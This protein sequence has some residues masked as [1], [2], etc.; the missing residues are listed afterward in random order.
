MSISGG[1]V[2][3]KKEQSD[4][5]VGK[6]SKETKEVAIWGVIPIGEDM[7]DRQDEWLSKEAIKYAEKER[8]EYFEGAQIV[9]WMH[10]QPGYGTMITV[11]ELKIH[12]EFFLQETGVILLLDPINHIETFCTCEGE[13]LREQTGYYMYYE[14]NEQMQRYMLE[15]P[16]IK[17]EMKEVEDNVVA[18]FREIGRKRKNQYIQRKKTNMVILGASV[19]LI[20]LSAIISKTGASDNR[21][22]TDINNQVITQDEEVLAEEVLAN[23]EETV[24]DE[25]VGVKVIINKEETDNKQN[26][27]ETAEE[28]S[29]SSNNIEVAQIGEE[30]L[31]QLNSKEVA[32][33]QIQDCLLYTSPSPRDRTRS[34]MPSSA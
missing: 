27:N 26:N 23:N 14:R 13:E 18:Q 16:L 34:R 19:I 28:M 33:E 4:I 31:V 25:D 3:L 8:D 15:H 20:I 12:R 21:L 24:A 30:A 29:S 11:K 10:M 17:M 1:A 2:T 9:G 6:I 7:L 22:N 5:F 32:N